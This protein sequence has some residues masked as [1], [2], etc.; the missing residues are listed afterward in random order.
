M[1]DSEVLIPQEEEQTTMQCDIS[2]NTSA[3]HFFCIADG[4][5][6]LFAN[7]N[8]AEYKAVHILMIPDIDLNVSLP[9]T[10]L[11]QV[12]EVLMDSHLYRVFQLSQDI[13]L[14]IK[15][16]EIKKRE[17]IK[18]LKAGSIILIPNY[19]LDDQWPSALHIVG[20]ENLF[21]E[22]LSLHIKLNHPK[23]QQPDTNAAA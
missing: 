18:I 2:L 11:R 9:T 17:E 10:S 15:L 16:P 7:E 20:T 21:D 3:Y 6:T 19:N 5:N 4:V 1:N 14:T 12:D 23:D 13:S 22:L 8:H